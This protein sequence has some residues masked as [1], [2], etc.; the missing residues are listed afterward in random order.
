MTP[1]A[2]SG[3]RLRG[4]RLALRFSSAK[5]AARSATPLV[6]V[7]ISTVDLPDLKPF[8]G[9]AKQAHTRLSASLESLTDAAARQ[10]SLLPTWTRGHVLTH[11]ARNADGQ[12][13]MLEGALRG[14]L[15]AQYPGGAESRAAEIE[16]GA[17]RPARD[18][19]DDVATSAE[20]LFALWERMPQEAW[21]RPTLAIVGERPAWR[22]IWAR[23]RE[24]EIHHVDLDLGYAPRDWPTD[25]VSRML[26]NVGRDLGRL[27]APET[28]LEVH[29]S[30]IDFEASGQSSDS[31]RTELLVEG[32]AGALLTW[33]IGRPGDTQ[34]LRVQ[35][36]GAPAPLP[37][38]LPWA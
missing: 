35:V 5:E 32:P 7:T 38:L 27:L 16:A 22:S 19:V 21:V 28:S 15:V 17:H 11:L 30:D 29:A 14:E 36:N 18:L 34:Q 20:T 3:R 23:W 2:K 6:Y 13:R 12:R 24:T 37:S 25:F 33:L 31:P 1:P 9:G 4:N 26:Q 8:V 10:P